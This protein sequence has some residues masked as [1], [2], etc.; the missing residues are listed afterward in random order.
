[1]SIR[2]RLIALFALFVSTSCAISLAA[3]AAV[4]DRTTTAARAEKELVA[5]PNLTAAEVDNAVQRASTLSR[6]MTVYQ[7]EGIVGKLNVAG[8][9]ASLD[10]MLNALPRVPEIVVTATDGI[11]RFDFVS[12]AK[13]H[14]FLTSWAL[15]PGA[16]P[17]R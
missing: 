15:L 9:G 6:K 10:D 17:S 14:F 4:T 3:D 12:N 13:G 7:V 2:T 8:T 1:M 5:R 11:Y 16:K